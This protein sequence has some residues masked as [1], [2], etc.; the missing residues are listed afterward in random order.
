MSKLGERVQRLVTMQ[1]NHRLPLSVEP[2]RGVH[3]QVGLTPK[4]L[5]RVG[6]GTPVS[7]GERGQLRKQEA[8]CCAEQATFSPLPYPD[9]TP[10]T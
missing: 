6:E 8:R 7:N 1:D 3:P 9:A 10:L 5:L 4:M 2:F